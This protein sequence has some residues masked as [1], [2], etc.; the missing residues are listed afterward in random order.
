MGYSDYI[1]AR[2]KYIDWDS[3]WYTGKLN[4]QLKVEQRRYQRRVDKQEWKKFVEDELQY[5]D[6]ELWRAQNFDEDV[7]L[8]FGYEWLD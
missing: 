5:L 3:S 1:K 6:T 8:D 7:I 2:Y 4:P